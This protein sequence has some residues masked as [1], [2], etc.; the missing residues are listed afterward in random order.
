MSEKSKLDILYGL[1]DSIRIHPQIIESG[2]G[3]EKLIEEL[4]KAC[5]KMFESNSSDVLEVQLMAKVVN[6]IPQLFKPEIGI[7][8]FV[9]DLLKAFAKYDEYFKDER[10]ND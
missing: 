8:A 3:A 7:A 4:N 10:R 6:G 9:D 1:L 5:T 2:I